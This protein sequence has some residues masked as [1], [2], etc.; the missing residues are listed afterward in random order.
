MAEL[1]QERG[2]K[3]AIATVD[4][5][6]FA[7]DGKSPSAILATDERGESIKIEA[8]DVIFAAGPWTA[9]VAKTLLGKGASAALEIVPRYL[10]I[11]FTPALLFDSLRAQPVLHVCYIQTQYC[12]ECALALYGAFHSRRYLRKSGSLPS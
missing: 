9:S 8:T 6:E 3:V 10:C 7:E 1:A 11:T 12:N 2:A 4:G 5:L